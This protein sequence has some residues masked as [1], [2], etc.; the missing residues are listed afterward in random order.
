MKIDDDMLIK[1]PGDSKVSDIKWFSVWCRAVAVSHHL[2]LGY[3]N[4]E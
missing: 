1:M 4:A 3:L 2:N